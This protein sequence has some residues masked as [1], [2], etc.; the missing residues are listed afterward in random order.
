[1]ADLNIEVKTNEINSGVCL[2]VLSGFLDAHTFSKFEDQLR[3]LMKDNKYNVVV[4]MKNLDYISSAGLG[5]FMSVIGE[6]RQKGGDI[7]LSNLNSKVYKV[8]DLLGFTKLFQIFPNEEEAL[9]AF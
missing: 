2:L 1:M 9:K 6:I 4:Q 5:V 8:F 3:S 7:K